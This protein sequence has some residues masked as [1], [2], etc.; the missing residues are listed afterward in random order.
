MSHIPW[1]DFEEASA[2][3]LDTYGVEVAAGTIENKVYE[4]EIPSTLVAGRRRIH[5]DR[6]DEWALKDDSNGGSEP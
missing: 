2:H 3:L 1:L 6:L 5:R 4:K